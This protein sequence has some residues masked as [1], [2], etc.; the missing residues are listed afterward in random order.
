MAEN[1]RFAVRIWFTHKGVRLWDDI[2]PMDR[3]YADVT[4]QGMAHLGWRYGP[5]WVHV[6][7]ALIV[8]WAGEWTA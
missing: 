6:E 5:D 3:W 7:R 2:G 8:P 1:E 4:C